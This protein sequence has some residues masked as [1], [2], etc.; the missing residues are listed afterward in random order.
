MARLISSNELS[1]RQEGLRDGEIDEKRF[2]FLGENYED[3]AELEWYCLI[4]CRFD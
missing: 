2:E 3:E 1:F 4:S